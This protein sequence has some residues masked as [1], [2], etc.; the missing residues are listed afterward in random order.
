MTSFVKNGILLVD[1]VSCTFFFL[2]DS[3]CYYSSL[4]R[5]QIIRN[6]LGIHL[7][8]SYS[9]DLLLMKKD[10]QHT[11]I[12]FLILASYYFSYVSNRHIQMIHYYTKDIVTCCCDFCVGLVLCQY[13]ILSFFF[14]Y[15]L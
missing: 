6:R 13:I 14:L 8:T 1:D 2:I 11:H 12:V 15:D 9:I 5:R 10:E 4:L 3:L 7:R